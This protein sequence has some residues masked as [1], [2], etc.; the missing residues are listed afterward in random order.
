MKKFILL[1]M[2]A[3][4]LCAAPKQEINCESVAA[5]ARIIMDKR[6]DDVPLRLTLKAISFDA[7]GASREQKRTAFRLAN[8]AYKA[9]IEN[10]K[11]AK[12][13]AI[14][15]FGEEMEA[16]CRAYN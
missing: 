13:R 5:T 8:K 3:S 9:K 12:A 1:L 15:R 2:V 7:Y 6:Q 10:T 16:D 11:E 4:S 14:T